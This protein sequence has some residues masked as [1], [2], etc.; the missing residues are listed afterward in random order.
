MISHKLNKK[1]IN[2]FFIIKTIF[3]IIFI[4]IFI[5]LFYNLYLSKNLSN[6]F[7]NFIENFSQNYNYTLKEIKINKLKNID[8]SKI[9][10]YFN[11]Y[12]EKS[13]FLIPI[14]DISRE[15]NKNKWI[16]KVTIKSDYINTIK[17][18]ITEFKPIGIYYDS[19]NYFLF[20]QNGKTIAL[21]NL[22]NRYFNGL[23][24]FHGDNS[25]LNANFLLES[26]PLLFK[27]E[28]L[29]AIFVN[30]RRW[31]IK[32]TNGIILKLAE[33]NILKSFENYEKIYTNLSFQ[34]LQEIESID[35]RILKQAIIKLKDSIND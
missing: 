33:N 34:E 30:N 9:E 12:Y 7:F 24:K 3:F 31:N 27:K 16:D 23:I 21:L 10:K 32:L 20:D 22:N 2:R 26:V 5:G 8:S 25:L 17:V 18:T 1:K 13:I 35:L 6:N 28:I 15:L 14:K 19:E 11:K 29:E 4:I